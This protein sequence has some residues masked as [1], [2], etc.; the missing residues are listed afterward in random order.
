MKKI[1]VFAGSNNSTSI[2]QK[3]AVYAAGL[4]E[5]CEVRIIELRE[6][7]A[8]LF[9]SDIERN[10]GIPKTMI[11]LNELLNDYDGFIISLPEYNHSITP[12]FKNTVDWISRIERR[13][14]KDKP[15]LLMSTSPGRGGGQTNLKQVLEL[16]PSWGARVLSTYS[17]PSFRENMDISTL[18]LK[19]NDEKEKLLI[20]VREFENKLE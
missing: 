18:T 20:A 17:L 13:V 16:M 6:Y 5:N 9:S 2:N 8:P 19:N 15:V 10:E 4:L 12:V 3:L 7:S 14:F 1:L 11:E